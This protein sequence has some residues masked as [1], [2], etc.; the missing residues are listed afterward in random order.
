MSKDPTTPAGALVDLKKRA[1]ELRTALGRELDAVRS[2]GP[3][4]D[5]PGITRSL[6]DYVRLLATKTECDMGLTDYL[7]ARDEETR[8]QMQWQSNVFA[9]VMLVLTGVIAWTGWMQAKAANRQAEAAEA[10]TRK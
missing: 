8:R 10:Q 2:S 1:D 9:V 3:L 6:G 7:Q 4:A 5:V